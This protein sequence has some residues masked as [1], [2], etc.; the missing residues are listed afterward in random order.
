MVIGSKHHIP[1]V[2]LFDEK[3]IEDIKRFCCPGDHAVQ[4]VLGID[5]TYNL[6][7]LHVTPT[8]FKNLSLVRAG[9]KDHPIFMGP[10]LIHGNSDFNTYASFLSTINASLDSE[11]P[12]IIGSDDEKSIRKAIKRSFINVYRVS[13]ERHLKENAIEYLT[14]KVRTNAEERKKITKQIFDLNGLTSSEDQVQLEEKLLEVTKEIKKT[15]PEFIDY[16]QTIL[17]P[18]INETLQTIWRYPSICMHWTNNNCESLNHV[19][20]MK[21]NWTPQNIPRLIETLRE[22]VTS[23]YIDAERSLIRRGNFRLSESFRVFEQP[24]EE[25]REKS[26]EQKERYM[27]K[28]LKTPLVKEKRRTSISKDQKLWIYTAPGGGKKKGQR[29]RMRNAKTTTVLKKKNKGFIDS[30]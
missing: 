1:S 27:K 4:T 15:T 5:K 23:Q 2:I 13:C 7:P 12:L 9:T 25:W 3:Q 21:I 30:D 20:K 11:N 8:V 10:I 14:K 28:I 16:F 6:G 26:K 19:L 29:K 18:K 24:R 22:V 17:L